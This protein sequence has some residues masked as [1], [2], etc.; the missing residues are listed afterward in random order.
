MDA[1]AGDNLGLGYYFWFGATNYTKK[2]NNKK[3]LF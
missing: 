1:W 3:P 2:N